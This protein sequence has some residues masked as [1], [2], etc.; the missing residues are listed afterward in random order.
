[1]LTFS[2]IRVSWDY[3]NNEQRCRVRQIPIPILLTQPGLP[4]PAWDG[5]CA[6]MREGEDMRH[7]VMLWWHTRLAE[8]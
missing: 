1:M 6:I 3:Y 7:T 4:G 8:V 2:R 5:G